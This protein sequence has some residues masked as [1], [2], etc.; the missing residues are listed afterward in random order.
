MVSIVKLRAGLDPAGPLFINWDKSIRLDKDDADFVDV[1][2]SNGGDLPSG[3]AGYAKPCGHVDFY[4]NGGR[5]QAG[6]PRDP[7][8][9]GIV[10]Q[11]I[12]GK[13]MVEE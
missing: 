10:F 1:V 2:H 3:Q 7:S 6:C 12:V 5:F 13:K 9:F 8:K 4:P 11:N